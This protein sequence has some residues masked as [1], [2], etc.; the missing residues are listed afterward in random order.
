M[1][2][3]TLF[4]FGLTFLDMV[5]MALYDHITYLNIKAIE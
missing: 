3:D 5:L 2:I 4:D 1:K